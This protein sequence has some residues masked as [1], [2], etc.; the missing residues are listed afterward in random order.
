MPTAKRTRRE[1]RQKKGENTLHLTALQMNTEPGVIRPSIIL[2]FTEPI[3]HN[4]LRDYLPTRAKKVLLFA[5]FITQIRC[6]QLINFVLE[7]EV[8]RKKISFIDFD[9]ISFPKSFN[10]DSSRVEV[11]EREEKK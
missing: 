1:E 4:E 7:G 10:I 8:A 2:S 9:C 5:S 3:S 6:P 11:S